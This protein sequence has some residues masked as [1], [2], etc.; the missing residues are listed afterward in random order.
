MHARATDVVLDEGRVF[1]MPGD[2]GDVL[3]AGQDDGVPWVMV[4]FPDAPEVTTCIL[5]VEV[6]FG[7]A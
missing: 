5:G 6:E 3:D 7:D 1:A 2:R 4:Q